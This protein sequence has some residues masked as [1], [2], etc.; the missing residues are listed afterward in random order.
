MHQSLMGKSIK[1]F[2]VVVVEIKVYKINNL[3]KSAIRAPCIY[4]TVK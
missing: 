4:I 1:R 2:F 3:V